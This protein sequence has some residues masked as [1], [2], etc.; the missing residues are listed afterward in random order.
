MKNY[1]TICLR[2]SPIIYNC[3][4]MQAIISYCHNDIGS[5]KKILK[6]LLRSSSQMKATLKKKK[7]TKTFLEQF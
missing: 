2:I 5:L 6:F 3:V 4:P 1:K 7:A